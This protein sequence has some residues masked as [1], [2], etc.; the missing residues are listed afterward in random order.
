LDKTSD[1]YA[2]Y[3]KEYKEWLDENEAA[4]NE[5]ITKNKEAFT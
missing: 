3:E 1:K 4:T 2:E 5:W